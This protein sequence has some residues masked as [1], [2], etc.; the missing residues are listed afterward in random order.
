MNV[1]SVVINVSETEHNVELGITRGQQIARLANVSNGEHILLEAEGVAVPL[2]EHDFLFIRGGEIFTISR[3]TPQVDDNPLLSTSASFTINDQPIGEHQRT[4]N[5][6]L[7]G[8][9][10]K[11][12]TGATEVDLWILDRFGDELIGDDDRVLVRRGDEFF[13]VDRDP[14]DRFYEVTVL[15]DGE[16]RQRRF[17]ALITVRR[18]LQRSL[19]LRDRGE[20]DKFDMVDARISTSPL[21][22]AKTLRAAGVQD[23]DVLS[24]TKKDGGG[25]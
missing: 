3:D 4:R 14:A 8:R 25:G 6:K 21:D 13:T 12:F 15:L 7:T 5:A 1:K 10:L 16:A 19:P 23:G 11:A 22:H 24:I 20:V 17:P 18:A 9:E 2:A